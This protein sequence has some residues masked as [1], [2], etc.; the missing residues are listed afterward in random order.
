M[1][2]LF[3]KMLIHKILI[4]IFRIMLTIV[5]KMLIQHLQKMLINI[6]SGLSEYYSFITY[7][8]FGRYIGAIR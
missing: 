3:R 1:V 5:V 2:Q 6:F 4:I 8:S 7:T